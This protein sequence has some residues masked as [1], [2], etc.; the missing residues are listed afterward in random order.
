MLDPISFTHE[1]QGRTTRRVAT[2][3]APLAVSPDGLEAW[4]PFADSDTLAVLDTAHETRL[5]QLELVGRPAS[6]AITP[7]GEL[8][9]STTTACNQLAVIDRKSRQLVQLLG[10]AEGIGREPRHVVLSPDGSRAYVS[11][12]VGDSVTVLERVGSAFAVRGQV[13]VGRR[14]VGMSVTPDGQTLYVAHFMPHGKLNDNAGWVSIIDTR[15][16]QQIA[17]AELRDDANVKEATCLAGV[18]AFKGNP[19]EKLTFEAVPTQLAG[20]FLVPGGGEAWVPGLRTA[21]FPVFEGNVA[22]VGIA[23][24]IKGANSPSM[25]FP[26]DTRDPQH[27]GFR[28]VSS[29]IDFTDRDES[30]LQCASATDVSESVTGFP[31]NNPDELRSSGATIPSSST[32]L[33]AMGV[34]RFIGY[35]RGGRRILALSYLGDELALLDGASHSPV[36]RSHLLLR[37]SNPTGLALTPDGKKAYVSYENSTFVSVL[38]L[39]ALADDNNLPSPSVV[40][41]RMPPGNPAQGATIVSFVELTRKLTGVPELPPIREVAQIPLVDR[42][43]M[44]PVLRR[45]KVLFT[46]SNQKKY[47]T[48]S[49]SPE[50][51]C[52]ACHPN[53]GNDGS[54]W[55]TMEGERRT[56]GLW[57]G[58]APRGWLHASG[59]HASAHDFATTIV[60]ERL[61]GSGLSPDDINALSLY[62]AKGIPKLQPP[63]VDPTR[64]QRGQLLFAQ[65]C[66][67]CHFGSDG[68]SGQPDPST[69][70]GS[71]QASGPA[72][73]NVGSATDW[74]QVALGEPFARLFAPPLKRVFDALRGDR[75]LGGSDVVQQTLMFTQ[76]PDRQRGQL[77]AP[78]LVGGW[79]NAVFFHDAR[80]DSLE[81]AVRD[82]AP[83]V[84]VTLSDDEV[85]ELVEYLKSL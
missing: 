9:L 15:S 2:S 7:D 12:Y 55:S 41:Y 72:L 35:S 59:T 1:L 49:A 29:L 38:D 33:A 65:K 62:V 80:V 52:A 16:L 83:R 75:D 64:R 54:A 69:P 43:P 68:G 34:S 77:R 48:L 39:S 36:S 61:G 70:Y 63:K 21:G 30:F 42:D 79:E 6:V 4:A 58:T 27:A 81:A 47:P 14:P 84:G 19:P 23:A 5:A 74:A 78:P 22:N 11:A 31:G 24:L 50:A 60:T 20:V 46:S 28:R 57:G 73:F 67:S 66:S 18:G 25:I 44:E 45:G 3:S 32:M 85:G 76:R 17:T 10:E 53:G 71:G 56:L 51:A 40:P 8:V 37:G 82:I 26:L 13:A